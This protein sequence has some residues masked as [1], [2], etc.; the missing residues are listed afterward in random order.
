MARHR[1]KRA[2]QKVREENIPSAGD[3]AMGWL[4]QH[5]DVTWECK[6][7]CHHGPEELEMEDCWSHCPHSTDEGAERNRD[8]K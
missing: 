4:L 1:Q 8:R 3:S 5:L 7:N 6:S 2:Q